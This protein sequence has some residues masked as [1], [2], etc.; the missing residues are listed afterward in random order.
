MFKKKKVTN[1][2]APR[3]EEEIK[4]EY[5][6]LR[7]RAGE[8]QYQI[9]VLESELARLNSRMREVNYEARDRQDLDKA[10]KAES[11]KKA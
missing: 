1:P 3:A 9:T 7:A 6:E 10:V 2:P 4:Q 8:T 11:E 5:F